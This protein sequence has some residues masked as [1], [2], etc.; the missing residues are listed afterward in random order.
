MKNTLGYLKVFPNVIPI[1]LT[2][3]NMGQCADHHYH[4]IVIFAELI[5]GEE[6][7]WYL[8]WPWRTIQ[9]RSYHTR[10]WQKL[11]L[12]PS[13]VKQTCVFSGEWC[14]ISAR[15]P[16]TV[17]RTD[18][19]WSTWEESLNMCFI[20]PTVYG[21]KLLAKPDRLDKNCRSSRSEWNTDAV[22]A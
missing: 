9:I 16:D 18:R 10:K 15:C 17:S 8:R 6:S 22:P 7:H 5:T 20:R 4:K 1:N 3:S 19:S 14:L 2:E 12:R 13:L 21:A 11:C